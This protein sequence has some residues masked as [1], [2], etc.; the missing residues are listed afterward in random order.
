VIGVAVGYTLRLRAAVL[1]PL[2]TLTLA[3][4]R[5]A[6]G[7]F[8]H[9]VGEVGRGEILQVSRAFDRMAEELAAREARLV[10]AERMAAIGQLAAGIAHEMNNPI[11]IIRGYIKTMLPEADSDRFREELGI[12]DEEA[13]ACQRL[14]EDLLAYAHSPELRTCPIEM[15]EFLDDVGRRTTELPDFEGRALRVEADAATIVA[16][17][18]R[19]RQV[20]TNLLLNAAQASPADGSIDLLGRVRV[21]GGYVISVRDRGPGVEPADRARIFEPFFSKRRGGSGLGL[22]VSQ[23]IVRAHGGTIAVGAAPDGPGAVFEVCLPA[24]VSG[25]KGDG[26]KA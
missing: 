22:S 12:L 10:D 4:R 8:A 25:A 7:E 15:A 17:P 16:D 23:G 26:G 11:G 21:H 24:V 19:V 5:F 9:R 6:R 14:A 18:L 3:A 1:R 13:S 20:L 2:A